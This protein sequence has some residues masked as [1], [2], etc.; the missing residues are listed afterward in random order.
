MIL[1]AWSFG[2]PLV[3]VSRFALFDI[4][5]LGR[6]LV[7]SFCPGLLMSCSLEILAWMCSGLVA[8]VVSDGFSLECCWSS[9]SGS[10]D[11][12]LSRFHRWLVGLWCISKL[13]PA[14]LLA[15]KSIRLP[16]STSPVLSSPG[17]GS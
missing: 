12:T 13:E 3:S 9:V 6:V 16:T 17:P 14:V 2:G 1:C 5:I 7:V 10:G 11:L 8:S 4:L 15:E